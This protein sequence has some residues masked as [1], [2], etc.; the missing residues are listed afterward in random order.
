MSFLM[1]KTYSFVEQYEK[2][3]KAEA[4]LDS[5]FSQ[6]YLIYQVS[7]EFEK[8]GIDRLFARKVVSDDPITNEYINVEYKTDSKTQDTGNVFIET[9]SVMELGKKGWA[10]TTEAD[11]LVYYAEPDTIYIVRPSAIRDKVKAWERDYG[12]RPV[13][14]KNYHS[15]GIP[16]PESEFERICIKVRRLS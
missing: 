2:G 10:W 14:N 5:Y 1:S 3:K 13:R 9:D 15:V 8:R 7:R 16:V 6:W 12:R 4:I 11:I